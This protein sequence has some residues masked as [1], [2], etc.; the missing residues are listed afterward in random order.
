MIFKNLE[1]IKNLS[2][3]EKLRG[4]GSYR[5]AP[6]SKKLFRT[7]MMLNPLNLKH[8]NRIDKLDSDMITLNLEDAIAPSRKKEALYNIAFFL[9]HL[10]YSNSFIVIRTN[11]LGEGGEEEIEFLNDFGF[12][13]IRVS[14]VRTKEDISKALSILVNDKEL[15]ISM[16]TKEA[17]MNLK[18]LR[19]D[20][21]FTTANIGILDL[22]NSLNLPQSLLQINN[23]TIDYIL[24]KFL[25]DAHSVGLRATSF[26]FQEYRDIDKFR[27]WCNREKMM[28]FKSKA[29]MG[30]I[31]VEVANEIFGVDKKEIERANHIKKA[32]EESSKIGENGFMD[33]KYGFIDE[34]IYK[35]A[36][37]L[38][39]SV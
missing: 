19:V 4:L 37:L 7:N 12:D 34:P 39:D 31:Q 36:L 38:L 5:K 23:P 11:P 2:L 10:K 25:I 35:D 26:M 14:K 24:S 29:C 16:E 6:Y 21:R 9:S 22:L 27:E 13:A 17:F 30:P 32:F 28:G 15:H 1:D 33:D 18:E 20:K 8:L 3:D